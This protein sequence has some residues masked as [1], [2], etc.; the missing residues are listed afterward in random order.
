MGTTGDR[1]T[2]PVAIVHK[3]RIN[4]DIGIGMASYKKSLKKNR[5]R[6]HFFLFFFSLFYPAS[7]GRKPRNFN[8][9]RERISGEKIFTWNNGFCSDIYGCFGSYGAIP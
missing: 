3:W 5:N 6:Q 2:V 7:R 9:C 1:V 8:S 4:Q